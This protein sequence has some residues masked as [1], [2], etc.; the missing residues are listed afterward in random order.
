MRSETAVFLRFDLD[1][2]NAATTRRTDT[3]FGHQCDMNVGGCS[4]ACLQKTCCSNGD[5]K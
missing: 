4:G 2:G 1:I 5:R 3:R